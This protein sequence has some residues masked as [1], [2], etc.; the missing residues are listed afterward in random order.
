VAHSPGKARLADAVRRA[1]RVRG[2][3]PDALPLVPGCPAQDAAA[4]AAACLAEG[5]G[6][7][8]LADASAAQVVF[9]L[10]GW[11]DAGPYPPAPLPAHLF[12]DGLL[13]EEGVVRVWAIDLEET[14]AFRAH[15]VA[16]LAGASEVRVTTP[17][18]TDLR[19]RPRGWLTWPNPY[20]EA[21]TAP[22]EES[23]QGT[24]V[25][26]GVAH[27]GALARPFVLRVRD[28][29]VTNLDDVP[30][31]D[32][33][34]RLARQDLTR[35]RNAGRVAELGI[36]LNPGACPAADIMEAEQARGTCHIGLGR[37]L[38]YGGRT[39]SAT[40]VDYTLRAP[41]I[42]A[43]GQILLRD[44]RSAVGWIPSRRGGHR[45]PD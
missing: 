7:A 39:E 2:L 28:G 12:W 37:N 31:A 20:G 22:V 34:Q 15:L 19:L 8:L 6:L 41:T 14:Q 45:L 27:A 9:R 42:S 30:L 18:G 36:G 13:P 17:A 4:R 26:D 38:A 21:Y 16:A 29:W 23:V 40:H 11:P 24:V 10:V 1:V 35:D 3:R 43:D 5:G 44:G 25:V 33:Q 32:A